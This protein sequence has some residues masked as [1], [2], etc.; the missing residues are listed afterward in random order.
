M[1]KRC[2]LYFPEDYPKWLKMLIG[3]KAFGLLIRGSRKKRNPRDESY[4]RNVAKEL[5][6][7]NLEFVEAGAL[8]STHFADT[9]EI[10]LLWPDAI[11]YGWHGVE[12]KIF[13]LKGSAT[14]VSVLNGRRRYFPF[15]SSVTTLKYQRYAC[16]RFIERFWLGEMVFSIIFVAVTP[17]IVVYDLVR[18]RV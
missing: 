10:I 4:M 2:I 13:D 3:G 7:G 17:F 6:E 15:A 16:R 14:K 9:D 8:N 1:V 5:L 12:K 18:G 11:G